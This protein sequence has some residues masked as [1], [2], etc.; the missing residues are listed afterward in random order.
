MAALLHDRTALLRHVVAE[1]GE[2]GQHL[3][4][5]QHPRVESDRQLHHVGEH[6]VD[7][8]APRRLMWKGSKWTSLAA[9]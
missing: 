7:A 4:A 5:R 6:A 3:Q 8:E 2:P 9:W 1:Y